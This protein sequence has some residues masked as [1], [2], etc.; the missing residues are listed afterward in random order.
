MLLSSLAF[1]FF[2]PLS[3]LPGG[4]TCRLS[5]T[6]WLPWAFLGSFSAPPA[7]IF[8]PRALWFSFPFSFSSSATNHALRPRGQAHVRGKANCLW[9]ETAFLW[10]LGNAFLSRVGRADAGSCCLWA[11]DAGALLGRMIQVELNIM[12]HNEFC[13]FWGDSAPGAQEHL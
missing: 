2:K 5:L 11:A 4:G 1:P 3:S 10:G 13:P 7:L 12:I 9:K 8:H 6:T